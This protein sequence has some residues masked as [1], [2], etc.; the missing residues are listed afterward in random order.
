MIVFDQQSEPIEQRVLAP[1]LVLVFHE[2]ITREI[3]VNQRFLHKLVALLG[4]F[5]RTTDTAKDGGAVAESEA[6]SAHEASFEN[7]LCAYLCFA[8][9]H[10]NGEPSILSPVPVATSLRSSIR[11]VVRADN[12]ASALRVLVRQLGYLHARICATTARS[13]VY[14]PSKAP[15]PPDNALLWNCV[16]D[17]VSPVDSVAKRA[18]EECMPEP[19]WWMCLVLDWFSWL[20]ADTMDAP[21]KVST[22]SDGAARDDAIVNICSMVSTMTVIFSR[23]ASG[24]G[25]KAALDA[26]TAANTESQAAEKTVSGMQSRLCSVCISTLWLHVPEHVTAESA[27][28]I[29]S[30]L[31]A[32]LDARNAWG[33][34]IVLSGCDKNAFTAELL[35]KLLQVFH[36]ADRAMDRPR[37]L[38]LQLLLPLVSSGR[39]LEE[40][41]AAKI[42]DAIETNKYIAP[43]DKALPVTILG[44]L[45]Y[46]ADLNDELRKALTRLSDA[47]NDAQ[48]QEQIKYIENF[49]QLYSVTD[50][51][52]LE[53][54]INVFIRLLTSSVAIGVAATAD[55]AGEADDPVAADA[56]TAAM[57]A[58]ALA[59][60]AMLHR[61]TAARKFAE[62]YLKKWGLS[63]LLGVV[64]ARIRG[65]AINGYQES[66]LFD[67][68]DISETLRVV[69]SPIRDQIDCDVLRTTSPTS[70]PL[71]DLDLQTLHSVFATVTHPTDGAAN[72]VTSVLVERVLTLLDWMM[73]SS[74][75]CFSDI[76]DYAAKLRAFFLFVASWLTDSRDP[77]SSEAVGVWL[78]VL[79]RVVNHSTGR[80]ERLDEFLLSLLAFVYDNVANMSAEVRDRLLL[81]VL[82]TLKRLGEQGRAGSASFEHAIEQILAHVNHPKATELQTRCSYDLLSLLTQLDP[83]I[84]VLF[85]MDGVQILLQEC[86]CGV[87]SSLSTPGSP[88]TPSSRHPPDSWRVTK[89]AVAYCQTEA[90]KCLSRAAHT[91][92]EVLMK[93]GAAP[94]IAFFLFR[95][96][97][98]GLEPHAG[99]SGGTSSSHNTRVAPLGTA[100]GSLGALAAHNRHESTQEHAA[101]LIARVASQ[102]YLR[103][104]LL[105]QENVSILIESLESVHLAVVLAS[106]EALRHLCDFSMRLDALVRHATVPV[107]AQILFSSASSTEEPQAGDSIRAASCVMRLLAEMCDKSKMVCRRVV[108]SHL[109]PKLKEYLKVVTQPSS[110]PRNPAKI[111]MG[112]ELRHDTV[113]VIK[114]LSKDTELVLKVIEQGVIEALCEQLPGFDPVATQP[115]AMSALRNLVAVSGALEN[116]SICQVIQTTAAVIRKTIP[117]PSYQRAVAKGLS[118]FVAIAGL[119]SHEAYQSK[120]SAKQPAAQQQQWTSLPAPKQ[121]LMDG[122]A[123]QLALDLLK[124][125]DPTVKLQA[126]TVVLAFAEGLSDLT[127]IRELVTS[128]ASTTTGTKTAS[129]PLTTIVR[130]ISDESRVATTASSSALLVVTLM[131]LNVLLRDDALKSKLTPMAYEVVLQVVIAVAAPPSPSQLNAH[132]HK[133]VAEALMALA[134]MTK[135]GG[136]G[137]GDSPTSSTS[138]AFK[139]LEPLVHL[140]HTGTGSLRLNALFLLVSFASLPAMRAKIWSLSGLEALVDVLVSAAAHDKVVQLCL[141]GIALLT[142]SDD[143][144]AVIGSESSTFVDK[145]AGAIDTLVALLRAKNVSVQAN[146]VWVVSNLS[147][148]GA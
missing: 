50:D 127:L 27:R 33:D 70:D 86:G 14:S 96:L 66:T 92:D 28:L 71:G 76:Y 10:T 135:A 32:L 148:V 82:V 108:S 140:V 67:I 7:A 12:N 1:A 8:Y 73:R 37:H 2:A 44:L 48:R 78:S 61:L 77:R 6:M 74:A 100:G 132:Q 129:P 139:S 58:M 75:R 95:A 134:A 87:N 89:R 107:L 142:S 55:S 141:L 84:T 11:D 56:T 144:S 131:L 104:A 36:I 64:F 39:F 46:N 98:R 133:V 124:S 122:K 31:Q 19:T 49:L 112:A 93:V 23:S 145:L 24:Q 147:T 115:K 59:Y 106:L 118:V 57:K 97:S 138:P 109:V 102:E 51:E 79:E 120:Q 117:V 4:S 90:L 136:S 3:L 88:M 16:A 13:G 62:L 40:L 83:A 80:T 126:F 42:R 22:A 121:L 26:S 116:D 137:G 43:S 72:E 45:G 17:C 103:A 91:H 15:R 110:S 53:Y 38:L 128:E 30:A 34:D 52:T 130:A 105:S 5:A 29:E 60:L 125:H 35:V 123:V 113:W 119:Q 65:Q 69:V 101:L 41:K 54:A 94:G 68:A 9:G 114:S 146:A 20:Q 21:S 47:D 25:T 143:W 85:N 99:G 63:V 81:Y 111:K 18:L